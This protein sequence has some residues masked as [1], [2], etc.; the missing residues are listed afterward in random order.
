MNERDLQRLWLLNN[1]SEYDPKVG[2]MV[3]LMNHLGLFSVD[4][5]DADARTATVTRL[6][7]NAQL[8]KIPWSIISQ[9]DEEFLRNFA[10]EIRRVLG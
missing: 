8:E 2:D 5:I 1:Q 7:S 9:C 4:E 6:R 3:M 10:V